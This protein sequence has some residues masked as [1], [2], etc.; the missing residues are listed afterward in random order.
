[1]NWL[2]FSSVLVVLIV[3]SQYSE[4]KQNNSEEF[5]STETAKYCT[6][7]EAETIVRRLPEVVDAENHIRSITNSKQGVSIMVN[8]SVV[9]GNSY[10]T[11]Q[12]GFNGE[13]RFETYYF[14]YV[15]KSNRT[16]IRIMDIVT[17]TLEPIKKW[18][19]TNSQ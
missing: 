9:D 15:N 2:K 3:L 11:F 12:V 8:S 14:F 10:Y 17:G 16:D 7:E 1:M 6:V 4:A 13:E 5:T 19:K 18:R